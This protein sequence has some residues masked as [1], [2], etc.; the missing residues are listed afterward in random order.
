MR[1]RARI[2]VTVSSLA[3]VC[4]LELAVASPTGRLTGD[5]TSGKEHLDYAS[6]VVTGTRIGILADG[7]GHFVL[8]GVP[9]GQRRLIVLALGF[10]KLDTLL[11]VRAGENPPIH[12]ELVDRFPP[13]QCQ[14]CF[15]VPPDQGVNALPKGAFRLDYS[16]EVWHARA[17]GRTT[18]LAISSDPDPCQLRIDCRLGGPREAVRLSVIDSAGRVLRTLDSGGVWDG[19]D[20][21]GRPTP[22]GWYRVRLDSPGDT[23]ALE[24]YR[25]RRPALR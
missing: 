9:T 17:V 12:L 23:L 1:A 10:K 7:S 6:V 15:W 11:D 4:A 21:Y 13:P 14:P 24:F 19:S 20:R 18:E 16:G 22:Y 25:V 5:V 8:E 2:A 3:C